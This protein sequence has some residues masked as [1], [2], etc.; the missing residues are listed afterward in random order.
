MT[1]TTSRNDELNWRVRWRART[2]AGIVGALLSA[3]ASSPPEPTEAIQAAEQAVA[4]ADR[5]QFTDRVSPEL[6]E[7]RTKLA[8]AH[9]AAQ[10][11]RMLEAERLAQES[12]AAAELASAKMERA[13]ARVANAEIRNHMQ[14]LGQEIQR[15]TSTR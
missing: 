4:A 2:G 10:E 5:M 3:C 1:W 15:F 8:A 7:A 11:K 13:K 6:S 14:M 12:R 9:S